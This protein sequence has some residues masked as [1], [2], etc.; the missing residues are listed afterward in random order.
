MNIIFLFDK[1]IIPTDGGVEQVTHTLSKELCNRGHNVL[2]LCHTQ[3]ERV[4]NVDSK[5]KQLYIELANSS[6]K[7]VEKE[8]LRITNKHNI[9]HVISQTFDE[10]RIMRLLPKHIKKIA[11]CHIKPFSYMGIKRSRIYNTNSQNLR[12]VILKFFRIISPKI[13]E[14]FFKRIEERNISS[15]Y[16]QAD[17]L[18]FLSERFYARVSKY[19][20]MQKQDKFV[21]INNPNTFDVVEAYPFEKRDNIVLWVGRVNNKQKNTIDFV[22]TWK[23]LSVKNPAWKAIVIGDGEDLPF[24][25]KYAKKNNIERIEF[26]G[27]RNDVGDFYKRAKFIAVTSFWESW[28]MV[29]T[30][31]MAFGCV[32]CVYDTYETLHDIIDDRKN[33]LITNVSSKEMSARIQEYIDNEAELKKISFAAQD[34]IKQFSA[35]RIV[36]QWENLLQNI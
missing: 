32:P 27:Q 29:I 23:N 14:S 6:D 8:L 20:P 12:Q 33:G 34:K 17:R 15:T 13:Y 21:A 7:D 25:K 1:P 11:V 16:E 24:C 31:A 35:D 4:C 28:C 36:T 2:Y 10:E 26:L 19:M 30:E 3:K 22:K 5:F 9:T 18:C